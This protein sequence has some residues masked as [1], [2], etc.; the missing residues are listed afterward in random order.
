ML[1]NDTIVAISSATGSAP[2]MILRLTGPG[3]LQ[4]ARTLTNIS[5]PT[6][7][8]VHRVTLSVATL[9]IPA[10]LYF[11][12]SPGSYTAQDLLE[13]HIPGNPLLARMLLDHL[14]AAGA[15]LAEPGEFTARAFFAGKLDLAQAEGVAAAIA[16]RT[17]EQL[18][19]ARQLMSGELAHRLSP[20]LESLAQTLS[21][22]EAAIDFSEED[23]HP[24]EAEQVGKNASEILRKLGDIIDHST[25]F[26]SL[27]NEPTIV[28]VGRPNAGKS[29][30][31]NALAGQARS[32]VSDQ[33]GTT[34]D[35][36]SAELILQRGI[37]QIL[38]VAGLQDDSD[39]HAKPIPTKS[40]PPR[41]LLVSGGW[42][43]VRAGSDD[44]TDTNPS[45][46]PLLEIESQMRRRALLAIDQATAVVLVVDSTDPRSLL[47]LRRPPDLIV[48]SK[49]DLLPAP[50][51]VQGRTPLSAHTGHNLPLLRQKLDHLA[52]GSDSPG[53]TLALTTRHRQCINA[54]ATALA[55]LV[56]ASMFAPELAAADLRSALDALGQILGQVTPDDILG[57]IFAS[58][59]I[60]K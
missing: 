42:V 43:G 30:L 53:A 38:D 34:R 40:P 52:F 28:F 31:I 45:P 17:G 7:S 13:F 55:H 12:Q 14:L 19:A 18:S 48:S 44:I 29:T 24:I 51:D 21:L 54:A 23:I 49:S 11:F 25:R 37:V 16:A 36:L 33:P 46:D 27:Q 5:A 39:Q 8:S 58:F 35:V 4:L 20:I 47:N 59:C 26:E 2:R 10:W 9:L 60:G 56:D 6:P 22:L 50:T 15:R 3:S 57:K 41:P 32:I 1:L